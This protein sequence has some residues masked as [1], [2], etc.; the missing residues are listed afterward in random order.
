MRKICLILMLLCTM[1]M[2]SSCMSGSKDVEVLEKVVVENGGLNQEQYSEAIS[3]VPGQ[4]EL[5]WTRPFSLL[6]NPQANIKIKLRL[7]KKIE[8]DSYGNPQK[9]WD[10]LDSNPSI[11]FSLQPVDRDLFDKD[12]YGIPR[13]H[14]GE[15]L[16]YEQENKKMRD[17][18]FNSEVGTI[19]E[20]N[21]FA[22]VKVETFEKITS[23][24]LVH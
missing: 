6:K 1:F 16:F 2:V 13:F 8:N 15:D 22:Y 3:V 17:L 12:D 19:V 23:L 5:T 18:L 14:P 20:I 21:F 7:N 11:H 4:Y 10:S 9:M 24:Q